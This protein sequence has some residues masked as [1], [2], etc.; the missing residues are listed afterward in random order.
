MRP[1]DRPVSPALLTATT[2]TLR[3]LG[4][5]QFSLTAV[6]EEAGV[7]RGTVHNA[8]GS[9]DNAIRTA[10]DHLAS[11]FIETMSAE[12][13]RQP[14]LAAQV[15]AAA[16]LVCAHRQRSESV[17]PR[18]INESILVLLLR[19][20]GDDLMR[21]SLEL[22]QPLVRA[23]Q[24]RGE[25]RSNVDPQRASE[26]IVRVLLSFEL[27]PPVGVNIDSPRAVRRFICDHI[28]AGLGESV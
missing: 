6:A 27:L 21:R 28:V 10:L 11:V 3:R 1:D 23:A 12:V 2:A 14:T 4:P 19:N 20:I 9:R 7:S 5:R 17:A 25:V 15:A 24:A 16:V 22:W 26:W 13:D 18:G 8:L